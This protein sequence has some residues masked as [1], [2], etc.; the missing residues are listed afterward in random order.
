[1]QWIATNRAVMR[2]VRRWLP[3]IAAVAYGLSGAACNIMA[4]IRHG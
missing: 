1:M 2:G 3:W 4:L